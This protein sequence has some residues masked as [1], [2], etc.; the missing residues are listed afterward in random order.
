MQSDSSQIE[1]LLSDSLG[2]LVRP[3]PHIGVLSHEVAVDVRGWD[4]AYS[5]Y[6]SYVEALEAAGASC[7]LIP[8]YRIHSLP[9][10][11]DR[12]DG[13]LITGVK[14]NGA[15]I[16]PWTYSNKSTPPGM[17]TVP[18]AD[19]TMRALSRLAVRAGKPLYG[20][21]G[22]AQ[23]IVAALGGSLSKFP[24]HVGSDGRTTATTII[25]T[26]GAWLAQTH[27]GASSL[28][29]DCMHNWGFADLGPLLTESAVASDGVVEAA[30]GTDGRPIW[31]TLHHT[32]RATPRFAAIGYFV[33]ECRKD[34]FRRPA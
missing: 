16:A 13:F 25:P 28:E 23:A 17:L 1:K 9:G 30:H 24:G 21:C 8:G 26:E 27:P 11:L 31:V 12:Y 2:D 22:G 14:P 33:E 7:A 4:A 3:E 5:V 19:R 34:M 15:D 32:D 10:L 18:A 29:V 20:I 6:G